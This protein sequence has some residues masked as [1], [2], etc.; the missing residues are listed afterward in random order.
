MRAFSKTILFV[1]LASTASGAFAEGNEFYQ[2]SAEGW[3]WYH[4]PE[5]APEPKKKEKKKKPPV[6]VAPK[7]PAESQ[8]SEPKG[9]P[10]FSVQWYEENM[11]KV[12]NRAIDNPTEENVAAYF[13]IHRVMMDKA[14]KF[15]VTAR[16]VAMENPQLDEMTRK[17][18]GASANRLTEKQQLKILSDI[19]ERVAAADGALWFWFRDDVYSERMARILKGLRNRTGINIVAFSVNGNPLPNEAADWFPDFIVDSGSAARRVGVTHTPA[20]ALALPPDNIQL[21]A[22]GV[23]GR[24]H[25]E[26]RMVI[27]ADQLGLLKE[28][29]LAIYQGR[30]PGAGL[31]DMDEVPTFEGNETDKILE[32]MSETFGY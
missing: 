27:A 29:E 13:F 16:Q 6:I 22:H 8:S 19:A 3:F 5:P 15:A 31:I 11:E 9:P 14:N 20:L 30:N 10:S 7:P 2:R 32:V 1:L 21:M 28:D 4:D 23:M 26:D 24:S 18:A 17:T 25:I 12:L